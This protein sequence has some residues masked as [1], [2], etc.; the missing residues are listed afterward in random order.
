MSDLLH[1]IVEVIS[2][3]YNGSLVASEQRADLQ[4]YKGGELSP[5]SEINTEFI[6]FNDGEKIELLNADIQWL[7]YIQQCI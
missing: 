4:V 7:S 3:N 2:S 1:D 6:I 5:I